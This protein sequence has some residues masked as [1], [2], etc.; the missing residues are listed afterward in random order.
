MGKKAVCVL[1][2]QGGCHDQIY[3]SIKLPW[4]NKK[5]HNQNNVVN[6][7]SDPIPRARGPVSQPSQQLSCG[8]G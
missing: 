2:E 1:V 7:P 6:L 5:H 3:G 4:S 8:S